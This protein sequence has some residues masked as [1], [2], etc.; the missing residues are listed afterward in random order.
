M[1]IFA[2]AV[3]SGTKPLSWEWDFGDGNTGVGPSPTHVYTAAGDYTVV[4][5]V[6]N[7]CGEDAAA[8]TIHV[9]EGC[10][11]PSGADFT[12]TPLTPTVG[13]S[14]TFTGTVVSGTEPLYWEWIFGDGGTGTG[15][16]IT[17]TYNSTGTYGMG[18]WVT[19]ACATGIGAVAKHIV[20][21]V[22]RPAVYYVYLPII[23]NGDI[24]EPD[25]TPAQAKFLPRGAWQGHTIN[26]AGDTDWMWVNLEADG[27]YYFET[28]HLGPDTDTILFIY[29]S[30]GSTL[31]A[32]NDD[33][34]GYTKRSCLVFIPDT[35][36]LYYVEVH[37]YF[38][39]QGGRTHTYAIRY[40]EEQR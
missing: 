36:G 9:I 30:D 10:I 5:T 28:D 18:L 15:N 20:T 21:V 26:P 13:Q 29:A 1:V 16:P 3:F 14:V 23:F 27:S 12:W 17:H 34:T 6:S 25:N 40:Y 38:P 8:H 22:M 35:A 32:Q 33:C 19:N 24:Y 37:D 39:D 2:G 7:A 31:L 4:M 11:P